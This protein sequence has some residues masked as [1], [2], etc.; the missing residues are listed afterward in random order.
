MSNAITTTIDI[1]ATPR[2]VWDVLTNFAATRGGIRLWTG[3]GAPPW[4][5]HA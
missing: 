5:A 2:A 4:W 1:D 3:S